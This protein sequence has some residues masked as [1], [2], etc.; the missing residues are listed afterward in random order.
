MGARGPG[1]GRLKAAQAALEGT[2]RRLPWKRRGLSRADRV[3]QFLQWLPITKGPLA[4]KRMKLLPEQR[5]F[6]EAIYGDLDANPF[7]A[8]VRRRP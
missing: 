8:D 6:V 1:A 3:I 4:G 5:E 7:A 2:K